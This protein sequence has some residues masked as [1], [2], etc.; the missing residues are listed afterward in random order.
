MTDQSGEKPPLYLIKSQEEVEAWLADRNEQ[1]A[2][3]ISAKAR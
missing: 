2:A 1:A 3:E